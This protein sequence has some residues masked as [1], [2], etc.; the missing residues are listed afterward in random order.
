MEAWPISVVHGE[1]RLGRHPVG[2]LDRRDLI[3]GGPGAGP[4][5]HGAVGHRVDL[6]D[7]RPVDKAGWLPLGALQLQ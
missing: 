4:V 5:M 1:R 6:L 3:V 2:A 7:A